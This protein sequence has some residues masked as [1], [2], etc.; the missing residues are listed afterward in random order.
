MDARVKA[1]W[2]EA[3]RSGKYQQ[4][5]NQLRKDDG[6][7]CLGVLCELHRKEHNKQWTKN[8]RTDALEYCEEA[9]DLPEAVM[10]WAGLDES[11][12]TV[13]VTLTE[14]E[15]EN[16]SSLA[17]QNDQGMPFEEIADLIEQQ[18]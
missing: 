14:T 12:P 2:L 6:Y 5:I 8:K 13:T 7:C 11:N 16:E 15:C 9:S 17:Y 4:A 1:M 10:E 3:L 18:L